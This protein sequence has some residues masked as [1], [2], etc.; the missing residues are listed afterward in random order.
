ML[1]C[2]SFVSGCKGSCGVG[3]GKIGVLEVQTTPNNQ[4]PASQSQTC[5][6][7]VGSWWFGDL[8][9]SLLSS[10]ML[11]PG[12]S[13][14]RF[15]AASTAQRWDCLFLQVVISQFCTWEVAR[16][17]LFPLLLFHYPGAIW[18]RLLQRRADAGENCQY[19]ITKKLPSL[20]LNVISESPSP[21]SR[22]I[23][24]LSLEALEGLAGLCSSAP[25]ISKGRRAPNPGSEAHPGHQFC[26]ALTL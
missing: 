12:C 16:D 19:K 2:C 8:F 7:H 21:S 23:S 1:C 15:P 14:V 10:A 4:H 26:P 3:K 6:S 20:V 22:D 18:R 17:H 9:Q 24:W 25:M 13:H 11:P 5:R